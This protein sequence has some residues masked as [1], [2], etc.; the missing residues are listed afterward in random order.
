M[1]AWGDFPP[2][3]VMLSDLSKKIVVFLP[4]FR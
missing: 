1:W 4:A 2:F 3:A